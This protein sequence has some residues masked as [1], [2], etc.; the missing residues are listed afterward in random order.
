MKPHRSILLLILLLLTS[1]TIG[2][3]SARA[4]APGRNRPVPTRFIITNDRQMD[5]LP[6][7]IRL[8]HSRF[9]SGFDSFGSS[10]MPDGP[11]HISGSL[12]KQ[13]FEVYGNS[14]DTALPVS[15]Y[16]PGDLSVGLR[17]G[18]LRSASDVS[19]SERQTRL[20]A[21]RYILDLRRVEP[22]QRMVLLTRMLGP[23]R[24]RRAMNEAYLTTAKAR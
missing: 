15:F 2:S 8:G 7:S 1:V 12:L 13:Q 14:A 10:V 19:F 21:P 4:D 16:S 17:G 22:S 23:E 11:R 5:M 20:M 18:S 9:R 3:R 24:A 6:A